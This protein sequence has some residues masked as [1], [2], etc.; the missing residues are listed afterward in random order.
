MSS[1]S[2]LTQLSEE[3]QALA[4]RLQQGDASALEAVIRILGPRIA[5][6]LRKRHP[7]LSAED[8]EDVLSIASHRLWQQRQLYDPSR[9]SLASWFF[10]IADNLAKDVLKKQARRPEQLVDLRQLS[11]RHLQDR[12]QEADTFFPGKAYLDEILRGLPGIDHR[13]LSVYA[14][15][16]D[17]GR[18]AADL[19]EELGIRPGT[20]RVRCFRLKAKIRKQLQARM[21]VPVGR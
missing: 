16:G 13:I 18:W 10:I 19:A 5:G 9:G 8:V 14:D 1:S 21:A 2:P 4:L 7:T 11:E 3:P 17:D 15:T 6:G 12:P 20:I